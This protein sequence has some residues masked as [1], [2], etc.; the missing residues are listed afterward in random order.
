MKEQPP[1]VPLDGSPA[2]QI[3]KSEHAELR[4]SIDMGKLARWRLSFF[5]I[6]VE[7]MAGGPP[8]VSSEHT[9]GPGVAQTSAILTKAMRLLGN[10]E[11]ID[12]DIPDAICALILAHLAPR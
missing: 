3:F 2:E 5:G 6:R 11:E 4:Y 8:Q 9:S 12:E 10:M 1:S 7:G